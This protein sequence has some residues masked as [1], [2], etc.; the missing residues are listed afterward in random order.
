[1]GG[2]E[3]VY[4]YISHIDNNSSEPPSS[5]LHSCYNF[6]LGN[7]CIAHQVSY[8]GLHQE[9]EN[10]DTQFGSNMKALGVETFLYPMPAS[11]V[12]PRV[13]LKDRMDT[14]CPCA[15]KRNV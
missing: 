14:A 2:S 3:H 4:I 10:S 11:V 13:L 8:Q 5:P 9:D 6:I 1:M 7:A 15:S 12:S